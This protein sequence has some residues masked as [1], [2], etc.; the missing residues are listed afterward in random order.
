MATYYF[1]NV[2][3]NWGD[4]TNWSLTDGG[5]ATGAVPTSTD[6]AIFSN[7]SG[8]CTVNTSNRVCRT[9]NFNGG[10]GYTGTIT[11]T[12]NITVSPSVSGSNGITLSSG[13]TFAGSGSLIYTGSANSNM[14]SNGKEVGVPFLFST[15]TT[16]HTITFVDNW[17]FGSSLTLHNGSATPM[18]YNGSTLY[19]K[20]NLD[21]F[22]VSSRNISGTTKIEMNGSGTI[23]SSSGSCNV[24]LDFTMNGGTYSFN[25]AFNWGYLGNRTLKYITGSYSTSNTTLTLNTAASATNTLDIATLS[26]GTCS[27][28]GGATPI[29]TLNANLNIGTLVNANSNGVFNNNNVNI[30]R[31]L[32]L[33]TG[34]FSGTSTI[35][36]IGTG[37]WTNTSTATVNN[38]LTINTSGTITLGATTRYS[39]GTLTYTSGTV[40]GSQST[41]FFSTCTLNTNPIIFGNIQPPVTNQTWTLNSN[42]S[43]ATYSLTNINHTINGSQMNI[44][45]GVVST[46]TTLTLSGTTIFNINCPTISSTHTT[47]RFALP[48]TVATN[49][50]LTGTLRYSTGTF[51]STGGNITGSGV[52]LFGATT[53]INF[54]GN[55]ISNMTITNASAATFT[56]L[57]NLG[58]TS[59]LTTNSTN[60]VRS[61]FV[62]NLGGTQRKLTLSQG[63]TQDIGFTNFTDIDA[64]G[65][66]TIWV[67]KPVL[68]NTNNINTITYPKN[69]SKT[70]IR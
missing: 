30:S 1:R 21:T 65:G 20:G 62:S 8:N 35:N 46:Q 24:G 6:D 2:G 32:T 5:G 17:T 19:C 61:S 25:P 7:N 40:I 58:I 69:I 57:S 42:L 10:T 56:L 63:A 51:S 9:L 27:V 64:S 50:T 66:Q 3:T 16:A 34:V 31:D 44:Y 59:N 68:S 49:T 23:G 38:N 4:A 39:T 28:S 67:W 37:T 55:S 29:F 45:N 14:T 60:T 15:P 13:M 36:L 33:G 52:V 41:T 26:F 47:G 11:F 48:F 70:F 18:V 12:F 53:P 43:A 22:N 54:N